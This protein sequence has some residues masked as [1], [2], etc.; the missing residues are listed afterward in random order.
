MCSARAA[1]LVAADKRRFSFASQS[2][3]AGAAIRTG[4]PAEAARLH[5]GARPHAQGLAALSTSTARPERSKR[6]D[7][8]PHA[9]NSPRHLPDRRQ[10]G[11]SSRW[12]AQSGAQGTDIQFQGGGRAGEP[13]R[14]ES[15]LNVPHAVA[16]ERLRFTAGSTGNLARQPANP[17]C[18]GW[19]VSIP[20]RFNRSAARALVASFGQVQ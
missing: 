5:N 12:S 11:R 18:S 17:P 1:L 15:H 14:R 16:G 8:R 13:T 9:S 20:N 6:R 10:K 3:I 4:P 2:I 7:D 19:T